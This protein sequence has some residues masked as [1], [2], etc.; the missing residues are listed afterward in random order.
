MT[1][2]PRT[3]AAR[4][5]KAAEQERGTTK[6][7]RTAAA[8]RAYAR[9]EERRERSQRETTERR[10]RRQRQNLDER[11]VAAGAR[12]PAKARAKL[13]EK[14]ALLRLPLVVVVMSVCLLGLATTL[15]L[16]IS[17]VGGS[18]QIQRGE[19]RIRLL[20]VRKEELMRDVSSMNSTPA[21]QRRAEELGMVPAPGFGH[22]V[23][24]PDGSVEVIGE[25][26]EAP[27]PAS[28]P[29]PPGAPDPEVP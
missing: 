22:L 1:A 3:K 21:L 2:P 4:A 28:P 14:G 26:S 7:T 13:P 19:E 25:P 27:T 24:R 23:P 29:P 9:R 11:R 17:A 5:T 20:N 6:R 16:S 8:E 15:W 10:P 12:R 18:Y